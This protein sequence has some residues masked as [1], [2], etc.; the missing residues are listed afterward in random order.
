MSKDTK[1]LVVDDSSVAADIL[2]KMLREIGFQNISSVRSGNEAWK[3]IQ[4]AKKSDSPFQ[5]L[6]CDWMMPDGNGLELI[7]KLRANQDFAKLY[8]CM[9][10]AESE[11]QNIVSA[12]SEGINAFIVKPITPTELKKK[13]RPFLENL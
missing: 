8:F 7:G 9:V 12:I 5:L 3:S 6:F 1:I 4:E 10:T 11:T 2:E 13:I